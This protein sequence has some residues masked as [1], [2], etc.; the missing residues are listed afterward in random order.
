[1]LSTVEQYLQTNNINYSL[2]DDTIEARFHFNLYVQIQIIGNQK[3]VVSNRLRGLN[4][5]TGFVPLS[6]EKSVTYNSILASF[7]AFYA[8][9]IDTMGRAYLVPPE[10]L[11]SAI[12]ILTFWYIYYFTS[13]FGFKYSL[14]SYLK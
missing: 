9:I 10:F 7:Y 5:L 8:V 13:Y 3:V 11:I 4:W 14:I 2:K 6:L 12:A 1:M